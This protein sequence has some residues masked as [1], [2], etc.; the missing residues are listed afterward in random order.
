MLLMKGMK[1]RE[2]KDYCKGFHLSNWTDGVAISCAGIQALGGEGWRGKVISPSL[3]LWR[4]R[5]PLGI[6]GK[7]IPKSLPLGLISHL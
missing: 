1:A 6:Q 4:L 7:M 5:Y 2:V 3:D